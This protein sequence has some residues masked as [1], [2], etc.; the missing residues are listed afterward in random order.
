MNMQSVK[1]QLEYEWQQPDGFL[2]KLRM[3]IFDPTGLERLLQILRSVD[4]NHAQMLNPKIVSL[5]WFIPLF[6]TWQ[7][8]RVQEQGGSIG[9]LDSAVDDVLKQ[10]Y[11]ILGVP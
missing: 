5:T 4:A 9:D 3:G 2:G 11:R 6:M 7:R 8:E 1:T 10:L